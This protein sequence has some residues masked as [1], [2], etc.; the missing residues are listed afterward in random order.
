MFYIEEEERETIIAI[1]NDISER[2]RVEAQLREAQKMDAIGAL[3]GGIAHQFNNALAAFAGNT[4]LLEIAFHDD[5]KIAKYIEPMK[6]SIRRM[7]NLTSQLLAY[8]K[9]G[10]YQTRT[11]SMKCLKPGESSQRKSANPG[12][13]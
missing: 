11:I 2:K 10:K 7:S 4:E 1:L 3:A 9:G 12:R 13:I 6:N 5:K 8:A